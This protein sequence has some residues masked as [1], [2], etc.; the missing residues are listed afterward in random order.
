MTELL[1]ITHQWRGSEGFG[2]TGFGEGGIQTNKF[3]DSLINQL[4]CVIN[5]E[6]IRSLFNSQGKLY[7]DLSD[8]AA[9][10]GIEEEQLRT[11]FTQ[12]LQKLMK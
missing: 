9:S 10:I 4:E 7:G 11:A 3:L 1:A 2:K 12:V 6:H 5:V 8:I